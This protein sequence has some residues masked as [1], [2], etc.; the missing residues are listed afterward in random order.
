M[1]NIVYAIVIVLCLAAAGIYT[2][3][4]HSGS[5]GVEGI[6]E[7]E[8]VWVKC[9]NK[10]CIAEYQT[11]KR[12][13]YKYVG[14]H[15][16]P[17][18]QTVAPLVCEKCGEHSVYLAEKCQNPN[19]EIVFFKGEVPNDFSDRCPKCGQSATEE[20]RKKRMEE[21]RKEKMKETSG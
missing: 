18:A 10:S 6:S 2:Y 20:I 12:A 7:D 13:Y 11:G 17:M 1:K 4:R 15:G 19:C 16:D 21:M 14:E 8:M 9:N 3:S 5:G